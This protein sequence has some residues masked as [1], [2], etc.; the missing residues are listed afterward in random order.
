VDAV[1]IS[2]KCSVTIAKAGNRVNGSNEVTV[3]LRFNAAIGMFSTPRW[4]AMNQASNRPRSRVCAKR[5]RCFR[6]KLASG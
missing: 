5:T 2:P 3:A 6:L 1:A 4:S